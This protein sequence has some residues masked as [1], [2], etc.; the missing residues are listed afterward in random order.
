MIT[1]TKKLTQKHYSG[2]YNLQKIIKYTNLQKAININSFYGSPIYNRSRDYINKQTY[3]LGGSFIGIGVTY[4]ITEDTLIVTSITK[5][6]PAERAGVLPNDRIIKINEESIVNVNLTNERVSSLLRGSKGTNVTITVKRNQVTKDYKLIRDKI[7]VDEGLDGGYDSFEKVSKYDILHNVA[8]AQKNGKWGVIDRVGRTVIPFEY[9]NYYEVFTNY[10]KNYNTLYKAGLICVQKN[11]KWGLVDF[12]NNVLLPFTKKNTYS[13]RKAQTSSLKKAYK[14][15]KNGVYNNKWNQIETANI[16]AYIAINNR[17]LY[18][19]AKKAE[20]AQIAEAKKEVERARRAAATSGEI[21]KIWVENDVFNN[22]KKGMKIHVKFTV[23]GMLNEQ[24]TCNI[25]FYHS[26]GTALKD[27]NGQYNT[28]DGNVATHEIYKPTYESSVYSD[29]DIFMPYD[30]FHLPNGSHSLKFF[31]GINDFN[32]KRIATSEYFNFTFSKKPVEIVNQSNNSNTNNSVQNSNNN[33][34]N[35]SNDWESIGGVSTRKN[36]D[37]SIDM[38]LECMSCHGKGKQICTLCY[39]NK[40][41][42]CPLCMGVGQRQVPQLIYTSMGPRSSFQ[43]VRC[44]NCSGSGKIPCPYCAGHGEKY[45][46]TCNGAGYSFSHIDAA[47][48]APIAPIAP[49]NPVN[50]I[51]PINSPSSSTRR[52][53]PGCG[54]SKNGP[55]EITYQPDYTGKGNSCYCSKCGTTGSCHTHRTTTCKVCWGKGYVE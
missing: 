17:I 44:E 24:G 19:E 51:T 40:T 11:G 16:E 43:I 4:Q 25:W 31:V 50:P 38:R 30:E 29:F 48:V 52:T 36:K 55:E 28:T 12:N 45:C 14:N 39:G 3:P 26:D 27:N 15:G 1:F 37:G 53:C 33:N 18:A 35:N 5:N 54:G 13:V 20:E 10:G 32:K 34:S 46:A 7:L 42:N 23:K 41:R 9:D 22:G 6:S 47:P 8:G 2:N 21:E 49:I